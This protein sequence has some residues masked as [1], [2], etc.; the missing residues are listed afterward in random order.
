[1][2][3]PEIIFWLSLFAILYAYLGYIGLLWILTLI[4]NDPVKMESTTPSV[5]LIISV[6]NEEKI[7]ARKIENALDLDY[8]RDLLEIAIISDAA[9]ILNPASRKYPPVLPPSPETICRRALSFISI[10]RFQ[11]TVLGSIPR[12][13]LGF[14]ILL[15]MRAAS[16]LLA[17][18]ISPH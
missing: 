13:Y 8:P 5:S 3:V 17:F 11:E 6:Y 9:V 12:L 18:S 7:L 4:K 10:T 14:W 2:V 15:S 16:R 1:M